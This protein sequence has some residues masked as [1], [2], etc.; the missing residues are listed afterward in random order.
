MRAPDHPAAPPPLLR[1]SRRPKADRP[2]APPQ[3]PWSAATPP[4]GRRGGRHRPVPPP[5]GGRRSATAEPRFPGPIPSAARA[6]AA[7]DARRPPAPS[8][9]SEKSRPYPK[10]AQRTLPAPSTSEGR[11]TASACR[12]SPAPAPGSG[13]PRRGRRPADT[14]AASSAGASNGARMRPG[15]CGGRPRYREAGA[16][17]AGIHSAA[18]MRP[19]RP[20]SR[21]CENRRTGSQ[22]VQIAQAWIR[23][24][25]SPASSSR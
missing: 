20:A 3:P 4:A 24:A 15:A 23:S 25:S 6:P 13:F 11:A 14:A 18:C 12:H 2:P 19:V 16:G 5:E 9:P 1:A 7:N 8:P 21:R 10:R 22:I 17:P